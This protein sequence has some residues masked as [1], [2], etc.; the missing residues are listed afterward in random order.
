M[1]QGF[2]TS[3]VEKKKKKKHTHIHTNEHLKLTLT[4]KIGL[5]Q[6][7]PAEERGFSLGA[8]TGF[9]TNPAAHNLDSAAVAH[10]L[11]ISCGAC[12]FNVE[13]DA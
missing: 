4:F 5:T 2:T 3:L 11:S 10:S 13:N 12:P 7:C 9:I 1:R 6:C 8:G